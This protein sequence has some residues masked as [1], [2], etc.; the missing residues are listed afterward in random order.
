MIRAR[1]PDDLA[2]CVTVLR[3]VHEADGYPTSWPADP[4]RWLDPA[5]LL[6]AWVAAC[7]DGDAA[8]RVVGHVALTIAR[9]PVDQQLLSSAGRSVDELAS[10]ARLYVD[11]HERGAGH[12]GALLDAATQAAHERGRVCVL[13]VVADGLAAIALYGRRGRHR[14]ASAPATWTTALGERP[15]VHYYLEPGLLGTG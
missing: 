6:G 8:G 5:G 13:D 3:A 14:V 9:E 10:I 11:P 2:A 7:D 15:L 1:R 4:A 12:A